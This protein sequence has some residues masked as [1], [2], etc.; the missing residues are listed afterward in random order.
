[1]KLKKSRLLFSLFG[2]LITPSSIL[3]SCTNPKGLNYQL[4]KQSLSLILSDQDSEMRKYDD[5]KY[6][7]IIVEL[8]EAFRKAQEVY[9]NDSSSLEDIRNAIDVLEVA[10][11][12]ALQDKNSIDQIYNNDNR[13]D[14]SSSDKKS[15]NSSDSTDSSVSSTDSGNNNSRPNSNSEIGANG[16]NEN[17]T[18]GGSV[19]STNDNNT[20]NSLGSTTADNTKLFNYLTD[21]LMNIDAGQDDQVLGSGSDINEALSRW[22]NLPDDVKSKLANVKNKLDLLK[23][24]L[25]NLENTLPPFSKKYRDV[26][27]KTTP[28]VDDE[29]KIIIALAEYERLSSEEK[30]QYKADKA[31]LEKFKKEIPNIRA[32]QGAD[33][34]YSRSAQYYKVDYYNVLSLTVDTVKASDYKSIKAAKD[35]MDKLLVDIR[36]IL[37]K[38][39]T[40]VNSLWTKVNELRNNE[41]SYETSNSLDTSEEDERIE[42][43]PTA[44]NSEYVNPSTYNFA[45]KTMFVYGVNAPSYKDNPEKWVNRGDVVRLAFKKE[46]GWYDVN[47][48]ALLENQYG[49]FNLCWAASASNLLHWWINNNKEYIDQ[50]FALKSTSDWSKSVPMYY[51]EHQSI[52]NDKEEGRSQIFQKFTNA[53][54]DRGGFINDGINWFIS[55]WKPRTSGYLVNTENN[56]GGYFKD[57][58]TPKPVRETRGRSNDVTEDHNGL[59]YRGFN[60]VLKDAFLNKKAVGFSYPGHAMSIWGAEFDANGNVDY[61][62]FCNNNYGDQEDDLNGGSLVRAKVVSIGNYGVGYYTD[63][64]YANNPKSIKS[65]TVLPLYQD[66]WKQ[67]L[68]KHKQ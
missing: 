16:S 18:L 45:N 32:S 54:I 36:S 37:K 34:I 9:D 12:K 8:R 68:N 19:E 62:Y 21:G 52:K 56:R 65:F 3:A 11:D 60:N 17:A 57:V 61:I 35:S 28:S 50:Y 58:F 1:M 24:R 23:N 64:F 41:S 49:D 5:S 6:Q 25:T 31:K 44:S 30:E 33:A 2:A 29:T 51:P 48:I 27:S 67:Y 46:Y 38:E 66:T 55:G 10:I 39:E 63:P 59:S 15:T 20:S 26:L 7:K 47:K 40:L 14:N 53:W 13:T 4:E 22:N 43:T 42:Y